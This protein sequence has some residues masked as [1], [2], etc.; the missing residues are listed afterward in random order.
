[1]RIRAAKEA[2]AGAVAAL[3]TEAYSG[4][5]D[6]EG[7]TAPYDDS[8]LAACAR[9]GV[10][11][12][13]EE[14][15]RAVAVIVFR[16]PGSAGRAVAGP[17]EAEHTRLAVSAAMRRRGSGRELSLHCIEQAREAGAEAIVLWSRPYQVDAHRLYESLGYR[18]APERD[19]RDGDGRR[20][21]FV[22]GLTDR[23]A[24]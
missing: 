23:G 24:E 13:G 7:R 2:D 3:W 10:V 18:R 21:V 8:E 9:D 16:P 19:S 20:L 4:R 22:L 12:V 15:G 5:G 6:G 11:S 17:G 1:M 14:G